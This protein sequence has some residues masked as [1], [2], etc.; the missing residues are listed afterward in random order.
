MKPALFAI[1]IITIFLLPVT[2]HA[3]R[4]NDVKLSSDEVTLTTG[5]HGTMWLRVSNTKSQ[6]IRLKMEIGTLAGY[7]AYFIESGTGLIPEKAIRPNEE[8]SPVMIRLFSFTSI[9]ESMSITV[10]DWNSGEEVMK[11]VQLTSVQS[12]SFDGMNPLSIIFLIT[13][14]TLAFYLS[15]RR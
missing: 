7:E 8:S 3:L 6:E 11:Y 13:L 14:S 2:A 15:F 12:P 1:L 9:P 5:Q 4:D 10:K